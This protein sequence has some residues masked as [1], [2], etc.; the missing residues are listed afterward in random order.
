MVRK[1]ALLIGVG[2]YGTGL[3]SLQ[4]PLNGVE[5]MEAVLASSEIGKFDEVVAL[6]NP[7][8]GEMRSRISET[9]AQLTKQDLILFYFTGHGL[10]NMTGD[11]YLTTS[12]TELFPS[13][14]PNAGT[15]VE[16]DFL[17]RELSNARAERK[18]VILDCCFGAA[19]ADGFL[20]M[21]DSS[22]D[23]EAQLGGKGWCVLT[24]S[25]SAR[26]A[27][28]KEGETLSV[29]TRYLVEGLKTGGAAPD[30]QSYISAQ[31]L[32]EYVKAQVEVAA[33]AMQPA[34]FNR[35]QGYQIAIANVQINNEQRYRK[36]VQKKVRNGT[37]GPAGMA[38]LS[39][40]QQ[41]LG[42]S[43]IQAKAIEDAILRPYRERQKH[44]AL[45]TKALEAE[46]TFA[47]PL[48]DIAIQDLK[49]LQRLLSLRDEDVQAV[50]Q[51][52]LGHTARS[53][54]SSPP[55]TATQRTPKATRTAAT[56]RWVSSA[57]VKA[58]PSVP[59]Q[60]STFRFKTVRVSPQGNM[61]KTHRHEAKIFTEDLGK[62]IAMEMVRIPGGT[63]RMGAARGEKE[64]NDNEYPQ[65]EKRV[66][67]FW[68]GKYTV[69]QSQWKAVMGPKV[70]APQAAPYST[71]QIKK[72]LQPI[73]N[74]FWTDAVKFCQRLSQQTG[75]TYQLP[76]SSQWEYACRAGTTTPFSFGETLTP[77]LANYNGNY[78]Y[79]RGPKG[80]YRERTTEV[81]CFPPNAFGLYDMHGNVWEWCLDGW[82]ALDQNNTANGNMQR[83]SGQQKS[84]RGGSW[85]YLPTNCRAAYR[86]TYPF[87]NRTDDIGF[88]VVCLSPEGP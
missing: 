74:I 65:R 61:V 15:A 38:V 13:G 63:F 45:Y 3:K 19:F 64:A 70:I 43:D 28:E 54:T 48:N 53:H 1:I 78:S 32:H 36:Q 57:R 30:G 60:Y 39:Q 11:F 85:F 2:E 72:P 77:D 37:I 29:Y 40:W 4:C 83:L 52:V 18:V 49:D 46:K 50:E 8:V 27:L 62:G 81:G 17:R 12:Q 55:K 14:R 33:P 73:E 42:L 79:G 80:R 23:I 21:N 16:A 75:R 7:N 5:A 47:Y 56:Q 82:Q 76:S 84:L 34:I 9:F 88:R 20:T 71:T 69:T 22:I 51:Q 31:N 87:H 44:L 6:T 86:L 24:A 26:Y 35:Q 58:K 41:R 67:E 66:F 68:M 10:K 59:A 25:T